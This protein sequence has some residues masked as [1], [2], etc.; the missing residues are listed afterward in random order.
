MTLKSPFIISSRLLP[1]LQVAGATLSLERGPVF[2]LDLPDGSEHEIRDFSPGAGNRDIASW[3]AAMLGFLSAAAES[4]R[5]REWQ[6]KYGVD[7]DSNE[8]LFN[9]T[10]VDWAAANS[11][12]ISMLEYEIEESEEELISE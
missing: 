12:E 11:D 7:P 4:R 8:V 2:Y 10:I 5:Y 6:R 9:S 1:A 3:F